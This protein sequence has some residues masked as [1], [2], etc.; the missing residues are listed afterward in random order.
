M[1]LLAKKTAARENDDTAGKRQQLERK[2]P[3]IKQN[4]TS[5]TN[6]EPVQEKKQSPIKE[7]EKEKQPPVEGKQPSSKEP[8]K[9]K[10]PPQSSLKKQVKNNHPLVEKMTLLA[11]CLKEVLKWEIWC[12]E[13]DTAG[14]KT[15]AR[16]NDTAGKKTAARENDTAGKKTAAREKQPPIKQNQTSINTNPQQNSKIDEEDSLR[17]SHNGLSADLSNPK[18]LKSD[19]EAVSEASSSS[20]DWHSG[21][22]C[23]VFNTKND[24][25]SASSSSSRQKSSMRDCSSSQRRAKIPKN[26]IPQLFRK[27]CTNEKIFK[28]FVEMS[29][30][31]LESSLEI[32]AHIND[33]GG[34]YLEA[35]MTGT[36]TSANLG[37]IYFSIRRS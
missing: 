26:L 27:F 33:R 14:K 8:E 34:K 24:D 23:P 35:C 10:Q 22:L 13:N 28:G 12:G 18:D 37:I 25:R 7:L 3:P 6:P 2:Q 15:A 19:D 4:R 16:E 17:S 9:E 21:L 32:A 11:R 20:S 29:T 31:G 5:I 36:R 1:T 30:I